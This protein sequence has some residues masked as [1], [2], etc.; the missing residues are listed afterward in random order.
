MQTFGLSFCG[1]EN[2]NA[3]P[4][5]AFSPSFNTLHKVLLL[6]R[7]ASELLFCTF[8]LHSTTTRYVRFQNSADINIFHVPGTEIP[9]RSFKL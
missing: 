1:V 9:T 6:T 7:V 4:V 8:Q 5:S 3:T 2:A